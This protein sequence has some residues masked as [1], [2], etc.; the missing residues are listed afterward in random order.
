MYNFLTGT[1]WKKLNIKSKIFIAKTRRAENIPSSHQQNQ[2]CVPGDL[3]SLT[4]RDGLWYWNIFNWLI[5]IG[6][7]CSK[8]HCVEVEGGKQKDNLIPHSSIK[9]TGF[10][11]NW[12]SNQP[13]CTLTR[14]P[15]LQGTPIQTSVSSNRTLYQALSGNNLFPKQELWDYSRF[16]DPQSWKWSWFLVATTL[17]S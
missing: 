15:E 9:T 11:F 17:S 5:K 7:L 6:E 8:E 3:S 14:L 4:H 10:V 16:K 1:K 12:N 2:V 13:N